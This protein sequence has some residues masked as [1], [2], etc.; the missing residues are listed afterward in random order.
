LQPEPHQFYF[1]ELKLHLRLRITGT[2]IPEPQL[3]PHHFGGQ[4]AGSDS[5]ELDGQHI[6]NSRD[7]RK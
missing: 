7:S 4:G 1:L 2:A 3:E 5:S 6:F